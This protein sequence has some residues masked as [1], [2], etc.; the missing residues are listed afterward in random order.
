MT[1]ATSNESV[2]AEPETDGRATETST[3]PA[4]DNHDAAT[5]AKIVTLNRSVSEAR[6]EFDRAD[7]ARKIA[8]EILEEQQDILNRFIASLDEELPLFD[9]PEAPAEDD[10]WRDQPLE[11]LRG[12]DA[13]PLSPAV[14]QA[15]AENDPPLTTL[16]AVADWSRG[17]KALTDIKGIGEAKAEAI[18]AIFDHFWDQRAA[19][20]A[21][22][23]NAELNAGVKEAEAAAGG[24]WRLVTVG[25]LGL[26][27]DVVD[28][29]D[30]H[31]IATISELVA[32]MRGG[33]VRM[34]P[35]VRAEIESA[36]DRFR[37]RRSN[38]EIPDI[39]AARYG[40]GATTKVEAPKRA[41]GKK[42]S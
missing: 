40:E 28:V 38:L 23:I 17:G 39:D 1:T 13:K 42:A 3:S 11:G 6:E 14:L 26:A 41:K 35:E 4:P 34:G 21:G 18:Q 31:A 37:N 19:A 22:A 20:T 5:L 12:P 33:P 30:E 29:L 8:K 7:R 9:R 36:L 15:L 10:A 24:G 32:L 27:E 16:G 2:Q 25:E